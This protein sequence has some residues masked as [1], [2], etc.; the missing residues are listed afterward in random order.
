MNTPH[1]RLPEPVKTTGSSA[2]ESTFVTMPQPGS[3]NAPRQANKTTDRIGDILRKRREERGDDLQY[4]ADNLYIRRAYLEALEKSQYDVL[5]ADAYVIGFLRSYSSYLGLDSRDVINL[6]RAEMA[7]RRNKPQLSMPTPVTEGRTPSVIIMIA[8]AIVALLVY[9]LWYGLSSSDRASVTAPPPLPT[10]TSESMPNP[11]TT[12]TSKPAAYVTPIVVAPNSI[13][14]TSAGVSPPAVAAT[15]VPAPNTTVNKAATP[16]VVALSAQPSVTDIS[17]SADAK[18]P[19]AAKPQSVPA[20]LIATPVVSGLVLR[21][22]QS[23]WVLVTDHDG[24]TVYDHV[25]KPGDVYQVPEG[26]SLYLTVGNAPGIV[27]SEN[28]VDLPHFSTRNTAHVL[29]NVPL[30]GN[31]LRAKAASHA[32]NE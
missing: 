28:G 23:S 22:E 20:P 6:Y 12:D 13:A 29:R 8:A 9:A 7:G 11:T 2:N 32:S 19:V 16:A 25:M 24:N 30:D 31:H 27:V 3:G 15:A 14:S 26:Q 5:P 10:V 1:R 18:T 4:I 17:P 21:A